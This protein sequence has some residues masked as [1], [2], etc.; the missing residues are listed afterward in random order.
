M[1][2]KYFLY[3]YKVGEIILM[4]KPHPCGSAR[5]E[6]IRT[7]ADIKISC[8]GCGHLVTLARA[9]LEKMTKSIESPEFKEAKT[10]GNQ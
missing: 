4:K 8:K 2:G 3:P 7:G 1:T 6:V 10:D 5:W 9:K